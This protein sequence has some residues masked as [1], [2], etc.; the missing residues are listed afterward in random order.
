MIAI[1]TMSRFWAGSMAAKRSS[2]SDGTS[3]YRC[4]PPD[5]REPLMTVLVGREPLASFR[6]AV[7]V[8]S[9]GSF[10]IGAGCSGRAGGRFR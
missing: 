9:M 1:L 3:R 7:G 8:L 5:G 4:R 2:P 6:S 10:W